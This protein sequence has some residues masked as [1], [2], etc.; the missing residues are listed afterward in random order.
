MLNWNYFPVIH[1]VCKYVFLHIDKTSYWRSWIQH[2]FS[3]NTSQLWS[4]TRFPL[5]CKYSP[6]KTSCHDQTCKIIRN[7]PNAKNW[8]YSI[9][10]GLYLNQGKSVEEFHPTY[11]PPFGKSGGLWWRHTRKDFSSSSVEL[12]AAV[13]IL[14]RNERTK[15]FSGF[16][17]EKPFLESIFSLA[18]AKRF[19]KLFEMALPVEKSRKF[20]LVK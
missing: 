8:L 13:K 16:F 5:E 20:K 18:N 19:S 2:A 9:Q 6:P 15:I 12:V 3:Q 14:V 4:E 1:T 10:S 11:P 7:S 17:E